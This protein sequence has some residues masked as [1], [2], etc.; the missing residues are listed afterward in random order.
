MRSKVI[1]L[2]LGAILITSVFVHADDSKIETFYRNCIETKIKKCDQNSKLVQSKMENVQ[3]EGRRA[4]SQ[5][6]FYTVQQDHLIREMIDQNVGDNP[7]TVEYFL[8]NSY[9]THADPSAGR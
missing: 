4:S 1:V 3:A 8:I 7:T 6:Q 5:A 9:F 2:L